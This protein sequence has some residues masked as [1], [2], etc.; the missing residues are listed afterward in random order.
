MNVRPSHAYLSPRHNGQHGFAKL[1]LVMVM[2]A[3][4]LCLGAYMLL[5]R[6]LEQPVHQ[7]SAA[8]R[9]EV[10][11]GASMSEVAYQLA[12]QSGYGTPQLLTLF[13]RYRGAATRIRAGEYDIPP[14]AT[15]AE[16]LEVLVAGKVVSY[17]LTIIEGWTFQQMF[18]AIEQHAA[19]T[20]T[21]TAA[22]DVMARL[23]R[24][25]EH[26]E[27]RFYPDTYLVTKGQSDVEL[28]EQ[29]YQRMSSELATA[30]AARQEELPLKSPYEAL[31]LASIIEKETSVDDEREQ[32]AGVFIRRL[33]K[34]MRLQ[35][36]PT[37]IYGIGA[38]YDG[39]I[40]RAH[41]RQDTP[42]NTYTR[43]GLTPT[44]IALPGRRSLQAA[45]NPAAGSSLYFV[46]TGTGDGRHYFSQSLAEHNR[47]V[48]RYLANQ[49]RGN[50]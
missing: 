41:L 43:G 26:P 11:K 36:D 4:V 20:K 19:L 24:P 23:G 7:E 39:N 6:W 46:A 35:T 47:A 33:Q 17:P 12:Q 22:G 2:L 45:V 27:G 44:P 25:D 14:Q 50:R 15:P 9:F 13:A 32:I 40:T 29:A 37:V 1:L 38:S 18:S 34:G 49:R 48:S 28:L 42:Y 30:W 8:I 5:Q 3:A 21:I 31:I 10:A 16:F